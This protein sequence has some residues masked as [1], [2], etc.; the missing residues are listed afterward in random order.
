MTLEKLKKATYFLYLIECTRLHSGHSLFR[1]K[2]PSD[3][4]LQML[5]NKEDELDEIIL[6]LCNGQHRHVVPNISALFN[7]IEAEYDLLV[8]QTKRK[9]V[10]QCAGIKI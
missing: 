3:F 8:L 2:I 9:G 5:F 10:S 4:L 6:G 1:K 7:S